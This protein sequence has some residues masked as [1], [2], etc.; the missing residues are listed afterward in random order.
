MMG[1]VL[2]FDII[3]RG[4]SGDVRFSNDKKKFGTVKLTE[5]LSNYSVHLRNV[6][7]G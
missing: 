2:T 5:E 1:D 6:R 7:S 3:E 4:V